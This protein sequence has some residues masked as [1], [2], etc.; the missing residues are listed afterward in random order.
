VTIH[1]SELRAFLYVPDLNFARA[2]TNANIGPIATP[3]DT[4]NIGVRRSLQEAIDSAG[5]GRPNVDVSLETD[6]HLVS[7]AP[8]E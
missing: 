6:G 5:L 2:Q 3:F 4:A 1:A 8:I 7:R